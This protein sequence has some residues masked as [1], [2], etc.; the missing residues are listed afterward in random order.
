MGNQPKL[1]WSQDK[2]AK[3]KVETLKTWQ[4]KEIKVRGK[5]NTKER[6][7]LVLTNCM[8]MS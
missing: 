4:I 3:E 2:E 8:S 1:E 7:A 5:A 6:K